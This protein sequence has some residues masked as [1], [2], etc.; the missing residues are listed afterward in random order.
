MEVS[1]KEIKEPIVI[2]NQAHPLCKKWS[3]SA[4]AGKNEV[5]SSKLE[6]KYFEPRWR[7][8]DLTKMQRHK[9]QRVRCKKKR[10]G[11]LEFLERQ[12]YTISPI[13]QSNW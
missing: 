1:I 3:K 8:S 6:S 4:P 12:S 10:A 7:P 9:L 5:E 13:K 2:E 11:S